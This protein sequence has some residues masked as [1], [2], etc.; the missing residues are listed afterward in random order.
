MQSQTAKHCFRF[1][2][3]QDNVR[4]VLM[5]SIVLVVISGSV[6]NFLIHQ[7][8]D[9]ET[10]YLTD[11]FNRF[12][13]G[14][15]P[16]I[17]S[18]FSS[19]LILFAASIAFL[20]CLLKSK[21]KM[22]WQ[23][24]GVVLVCLAVDETVMFHEMLNA[25]MKAGG[26]SESQ[27]Y[28]PWTVLGAL[29]VIVVFIVTLPILIQSQRKYSIRFVAAGAIYV[30]G[31]IGVENIAANIFFHAGSEAEGVKTISHWIAQTIEETLEMVGMAFFAISALANLGDGELVFETQDS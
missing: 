15:E 10:S 22:S 29:F 2:S 28:F 20:N 17:P 30:T 24:A 21:A 1:S 31:A 13:L 26:F 16:S 14:H 7:V 11:I 3:I 12:D 6:A 18:F 5:W 27:F 4:S 19:V 9:D 8:V 23:V 25:G